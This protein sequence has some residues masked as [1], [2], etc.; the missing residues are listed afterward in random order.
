VPRSGD[1]SGVVLRLLPGGFKRLADDSSVRASAR[2]HPRAHMH[3]RA[4][5]CTP[6]AG[7]GPRATP[8]RLRQRRLPRGDGLAAQ[9]DETPGTDGRNDRN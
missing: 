8:L 1:R 2:A 3:A 7:L 6:A 5:T 4:R 9:D